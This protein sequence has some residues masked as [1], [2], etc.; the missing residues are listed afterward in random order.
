MVRIPRRLLASAAALAFLPA[1]FA[2]S[3]SF[4]YGSQKVR[5]VSLG[6][7]LVLEVSM[8]FFFFSLVR[9][10]VNIDAPW[11]MQPWIT[12]SLFDNTGNPNIIDEWTFGQLQD[13]NVA[14]Q[15]LQAHWDTWIT[16]SDFAA[17][18]A[19]G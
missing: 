1:A 5:G 15:T 14:Q 16:E 18:A 2:F 13:Q 10:D 6:G 19:A 4:P 17:I 7:W 3:P 12:P 11:R 8:S 9:V